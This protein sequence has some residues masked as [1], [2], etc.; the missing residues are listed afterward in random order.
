MTPRQTPARLALTILALAY[1]FG[2]GAYFFYGYV[3]DT[4]LSG[5]LNTW[6]MQAFGE[7]SR[8]LTQVG[9]LVAW[10]LGIVPFV[11]PLTLLNRKENFTPAAPAQYPAVWP[12]RSRVISALVVVAITGGI[13]FYLTQRD[14]HL[15]VQP[16]HQFDLDQ[17][18]AL[19]P[20][21]EL[22]NIRGVVAVNYMFVVVEKSSSGHPTR[23][24]YAPMLP[25]N[26][27]PGQ[28]VRYVL[29]TQATAYAD[30]RTHQVSML[31]SGRA[32]VAT[33]DGRL[34]TNDLP[35]FVT[36]SYSQQH[37]TL[38]SPYYVLDDE[39]V[40]DGHAVLSSDL[41]RWMVLGFGLLM[42]LMLLL[43]RTYR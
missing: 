13:Y 43:R 16:L 15:A 22:A 1:I 32:F 26:W 23:N 20:D 25:T 40:Y 2:G 29:K 6:Q 37:L 4:G 12:L 18:Q 36:H 8:G 28:P 30:P 27:Q 10:L 42:A 5:W 19:P 11:W 7:A 21:A 14:A 31:D 41:T 33:Y 34:S 35:T 24:S 39:A 17:A 9:T 38:A 3:N